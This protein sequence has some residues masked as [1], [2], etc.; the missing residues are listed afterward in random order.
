MNRASPRALLFVQVCAAH[1]LGLVVT[2]LYGTIGTTAGF[3]SGFGIAAVLG[4]IL[5]IPWFCARTLVIWFWGTWLAR[6]ALVLPLIGPFMVCGT[7]GAVFGFPL[8]SAV[9]M[10]CITS[11]IVLLLCIAW[12]RARQFSTNARRDPTTRR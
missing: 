10:S 2:D 9:P 8:L 1:L 6:Y 7:F 3:G 11:S 12:Q 4:G 5:S